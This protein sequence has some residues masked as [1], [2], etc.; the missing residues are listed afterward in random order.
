MKRYFSND[1]DDGGIDF[2]D[3]EEQARDAAK[4]I[5]ERWRQYAIEDNEWPHYADQICWGEI[6]QIAVDMGIDEFTDY[7]LRE[8]TR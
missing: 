4:E 2:W 5:L 1:P 7:E 8:P 6:K 3:T